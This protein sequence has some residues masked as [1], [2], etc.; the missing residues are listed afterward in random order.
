MPADTDA[1]LHTALRL[2]TALDYQRSDLAKW[3]DYYDGAQ[4]LAYMQPELLT[5]LEGRVRQVVI[6]WPRLV[7]DSLEERLDVEGFRLGDDVDD[8]LWG[9]WQA[10]GLDLGSQQGHLDALICG[11]S[12]VIVGTSAEDPDV[13]LITVESP[14]Q[15]WAARDP[16]TRQVTAAV[17][18]WRDQAWPLGDSGGPGTE[19]LTC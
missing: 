1:M 6:N 14:E 15:V 8:E 4:P 5:E 3:Q 16:R 18:A 7:V 11:R 13:P 2:R 9:W 10:N 17:K 12:Y 19:W